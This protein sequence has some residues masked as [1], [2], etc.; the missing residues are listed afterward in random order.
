MTAKAAI[1][2]V[3]VIFDVGGVVC[4]MCGRVVLNLSG[5]LALLLPTFLLN[6]NLLLRFP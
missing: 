5:F 2:K 3:D 1:L 4:A 6:G